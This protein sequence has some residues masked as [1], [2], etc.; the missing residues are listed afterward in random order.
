ML[1]TFVLLPFLSASS[2]VPITL[3]PAGYYLAF[4]SNY[5]LTG[6]VYFLRFLWSLSVEEQFYIVWGLCLVLFQKRLVSCVWIFIAVSVI[7]T[8]Y[9]ISK[10]IYHDFHTLTYL[11]D[12][13]VGILAAVLLQRGHPIIDFFRKI[14]KGKAVIFFLSAPVIFVIIFC[15]MYISP[16]SYVPWLDLIGRYIFLFYIGLVIIEQM[17]NER[18]L[19]RL[20][21]QR[22]LVY[23]GKISYGLYCFHGYT[24]TFGLYLLDKWNI[25]MP[26]ILVI[27]LLFTINFIIAAGS[28][29]LIEKPFLRLKEK[30]RRA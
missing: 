6:H 15:I 28:Y 21:S 24:L 19:L 5:Y 14:S 17:V 3:P 22:F 10:E 20:G 8:A 27:L 2:K 13:A 25:A 29:R 4:I 23:T 12:F 18:T 26:G 30:L 7:Y 11:F 1:F 16:R 9:A